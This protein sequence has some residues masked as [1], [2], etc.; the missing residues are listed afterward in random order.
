MSTGDI[1][2]DT[3]TDVEKALE[4][5]TNWTVT[6][7]KQT[8]SDLWDQA[9]STTF[10]SKAFTDNLITSTPVLQTLKKTRGD[11]KIGYAMNSAKAG[12]PVMVQIGITSEIK[13]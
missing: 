4:A 3:R 8:F 10:N 9:W 6:P 7:K 11:C 5:L 13:A 2:I 12:E 1:T